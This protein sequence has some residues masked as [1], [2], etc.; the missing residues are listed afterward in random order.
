MIPP[1]VSTSVTE[2]ATSTSFFASHGAQG[3]IVSSSG[4]ASTGL[5]ETAD[6]RSPGE[7]ADTPVQG[8]HRVQVKNNKGEK[9]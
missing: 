8:R 7:M 1:G 5:P 2:R 9:I 6:I 3:P 4:P